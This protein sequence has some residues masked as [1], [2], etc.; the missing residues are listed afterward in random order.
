M[1]KKLK[2][3]GWD[4]NFS[5]SVKNGL[6]MKDEKVF[7][8]TFS[9]NIVKGWFDTEFDSKQED[10]DIQDNPVAWHPINRNER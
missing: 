8:K 10:W 3:K 6:P 5:T 4:E 7:F 1:S 9:G 2:S